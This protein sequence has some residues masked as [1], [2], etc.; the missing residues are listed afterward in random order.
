[1]MPEDF[2]ISLRRVVIASAMRTAITTRRIKDQFR[3]RK[4]MSS[5]QSF[6]VALLNPA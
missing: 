2:A 3:T 5:S 4:R 6:P 1:M